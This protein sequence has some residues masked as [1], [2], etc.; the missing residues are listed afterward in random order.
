MEDVK[1]GEKKESAKKNCEGFTAEPPGRKKRFDK[2][3]KRKG[4]T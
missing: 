1:K 4:V 2:C 3:Q